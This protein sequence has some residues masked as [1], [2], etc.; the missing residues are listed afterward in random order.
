MITR[1]FLN[2]GYSWQTSQIWEADLEN[3]T[4]K[5]WREFAGI[6]GTNVRVWLLG[7]DTTFRR[8]V[9]TMN[10]RAR[11]WTGAG[12]K[13]RSTTDLSKGS[14]GTM[15]QWS[16]T[17]RQKACPCVWYRRSVSNPN[18]SMT[19]KKACTVQGFD[20][21]FIFLKGS[22]RSLNIGIKH[23]KQVVIQWQEI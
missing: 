18:D 15:D 23:E 2:T 3:W 13:G 21:Q 9:F 7:E 17:E 5:V 8:L 14:P 11:C 22:N 12:S 10:S 4:S 16:K 6:L 20:I 19:G 1:Q